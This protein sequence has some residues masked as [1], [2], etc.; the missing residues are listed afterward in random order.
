MA[1]ARSPFAFVGCHELRENLGRRAFDERELMEALEQVPTGSVAHHVFGGL[2]RH[3]HG[4]G[5]YVNDFASWVAL[6]VRDRAL[7]ERLA[8]LDPFDC[9]DLERLREGL[10]AIIDD[11]LARLPVV[12]RVVFG[13]PFCF[14]DSHLVE[15]PTTLEARTLADFRNGLAEVD[16]SAI[17]FH[18][19]EAR[20][21]HRQGTSDFAAWLRDALDRADLAEQVER[22]DVYF[23]SLERVRAQI[24]TVLD[25]AIASDFVV[26]A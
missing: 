6:H 25:A 5:P 22:V 20:V 16:A 4:V 7:G 1:D 21:R 17:Y 8:A 26:G 19:V 23:L 24:L 11:H 14:V 10:I 15:V 13:E 9:A 2:L 18:I 3:R 12:P